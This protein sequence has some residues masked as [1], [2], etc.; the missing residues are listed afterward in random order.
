MGLNLKNSKHVIGSDDGP[1]IESTAHM[2]DLGAYVFKDL[3]T[4]EIIH[5]ESFTDA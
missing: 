1:F 3:N 2:V 4:G 5:E